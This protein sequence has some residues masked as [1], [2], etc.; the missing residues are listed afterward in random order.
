LHILGSKFFY[1]EFDD[2]EKRVVFNVFKTIQKD[3]IQN[4]IESRLNDLPPMDPNQ[5]LW[6]ADLIS[7][8]EEE[9]TILIWQFHSIT[10]G[11]ALMLLLKEF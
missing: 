4:F 7:H 9:H 1:H 5:L 6:T 3:E 8:S 10:D 2:S 11:V